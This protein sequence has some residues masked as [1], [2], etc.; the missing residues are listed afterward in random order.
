M[1]HEAPNAAAWLVLA[2]HCQQQNQSSAEHLSAMSEGATHRAPAATAW[3][4]RISVGSD[5]V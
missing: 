3:E 2:V 4:V 1:L 5:Y